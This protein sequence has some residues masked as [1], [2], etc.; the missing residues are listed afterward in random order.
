MQKKYSFQSFGLNALIIKFDKP[1]ET[2][3]EILSRSYFRNLMADFLKEETE[4]LLLTGDSLT[5]VFNHSPSIDLANKFAIKANKI[6]YSK[7]IDFKYHHWE[8]PVCFH[9]KFSEDLIKYFSGNQLKAREY[10]DKLCQ[11]EMIVQFYG[12][13]PGF[14]YLIGLPKGMQLKRKDSPNLNIPKGSLAVGGGYA[15]VYPQN[16]PGGWNLIGIT[17]IPF[18]NSSKNPPCFASPGDK[19]SFKEIS[20]AEYNKVSI[21][22][23]PLFKICNVKN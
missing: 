19:F 5:I 22:N 17:T 2:H 16:S 23:I 20:L 3:I 12:F 11:T 18:F 13:L 15:G 14:C 21:K 7:A 9:K 10:I 8:I 1:A 4:D 6:I